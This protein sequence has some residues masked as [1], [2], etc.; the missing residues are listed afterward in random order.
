MNKV[1]NQE[2]NSAVIR[3][4]LRRDRFKYDQKDIGDSDVPS[5]VELVKVK[6][7]SNIYVPVFSCAGLVSIDRHEIEWLRAVGNLMS[8]YI[9]GNRDLPLSIAV[10]GKP[11]SGKSFA[12]KSL[13]TELNKSASKSTRG[14]EIHEFNLSQMG[15][16]NDLEDMINVIREENLQGNVP[17]VFV[18][19]FDSKYRADPYGW[20]KF[21]LSPMNDG[22]FKTKGQVGKNGK[23]NFLFRG[24]YVLHV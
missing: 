21:F 2:Q 7:A 15:S 20:L 12:V 5:L 4:I 22:T 8:S 10:F 19:E 11:G 16:I 6:Q 14:I 13:A 17:L 18:D 3:S 23:G 9:Q 1:F 24:R